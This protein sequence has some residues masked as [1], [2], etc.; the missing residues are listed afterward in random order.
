MKAR[1]RRVAVAT[2]LLA[3]QKQLTTYNFAISYYIR[4]RFNA[5]KYWWQTDVFRI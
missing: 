5:V 1:R 3:N 4:Y 2:A